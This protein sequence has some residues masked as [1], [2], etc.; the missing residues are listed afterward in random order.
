MTTNELLAR[1]QGWELDYKGNLCLLIPAC[2][3]LYNVPDYL[4]DPTACMSLLDTL[5]E[6]GFYPD[7]SFCEAGVNT[8][9]FL[10]HVRIFDGEPWTVG[11]TL[12]D[13]II[14]AC[15][16]VAKCELNWKEQGE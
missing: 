13:A 4:N 8:S 11:S 3:V 7:L 6:K 15:L 2:G 9:K 10:W 5:V 1:W 16:D 12:C 14:A